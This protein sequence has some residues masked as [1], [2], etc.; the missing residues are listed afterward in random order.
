MKIVM[1]DYDP[2]T[3]SYVV[4]YQGDPRYEHLK[5]H[6]RFVPGPSPQTTAVKWLLDY[7]PFD[8]NTPPPNDLLALNLPQD[9]F[10]DLA[11]HLESTE[12]EKQ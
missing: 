12:S 2:S 6:V 1:Q 5:F 9:I 7:S 4:D 3:L 10:K 8:A 11:A